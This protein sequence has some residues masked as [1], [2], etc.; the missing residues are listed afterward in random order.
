MRNLLKPF[1]CGQPTSHIRTDRPTSAKGDNAKRCISPNDSHRQIKPPFAVQATSD[2]CNEILLSW[3]YSAVSGKQHT[4][5][6]FDT[7]HL[8]GNLSASIGLPWFLP[9]SLPPTVLVET[10]KYMEGPYLSIFFYLTHC[11]VGRKYE[12]CSSP[13]EGLSTWHS[14]PSGLIR[15]DH[16]CRLPL[17][18]YS[19]R[20]TKYGGFIP[21][22]FL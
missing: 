9:R 14:I 8:I 20:R 10:S 21:A 15:R 16:T 7:P 13:S 19:V 22:G 18:Q 4:G 6:A 3:F 12:V 5:G 1:S 17:A 2:N 11:S